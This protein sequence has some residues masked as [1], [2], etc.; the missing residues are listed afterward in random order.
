VAGPGVPWKQELWCARSPWLLDDMAVGDSPLDRKLATTNADLVFHLVSEPNTWLS[1]FLAAHTRYIECYAASQTA[2]SVPIA[3]RSERNHAFNAN[4]GVSNL[5]KTIPLTEEDLSTLA[6]V[7][8]S[9]LSPD[10]GES[11]TP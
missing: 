6:H 11:P 8:M 1:H 5:L 3:S 2:T 9:Y 7:L 4:D 10:C